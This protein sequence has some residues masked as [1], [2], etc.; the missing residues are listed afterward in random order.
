M[1]PFSEVDSRYLG[2]A[3]T[4]YRDRWHPPAFRTNG[5]V[6]EQRR[7]SCP[8]AAVALNVHLP[9]TRYG[10][11][12]LIA[13]PGRDTVPVFDVSMSVGRWRL[14]DRAPVALAKLQASPGW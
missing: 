1:G 9:F 10:A 11:I 2:R 14:V 5:I 12:G 7:P 4:R 3:R 13:V 8:H 6:N